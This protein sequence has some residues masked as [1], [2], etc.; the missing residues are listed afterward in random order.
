MH[1]FKDLR[2]WQQSRLFCKSVYLA[3]K[4]FP[5]D[6]RYGITSQMRRAV[7][8]IP[9]NI[10]EGAS[11]KSNKDYSRFLEIALGSCYELET[12]LIIA[13]DLSFLDLKKFEELS[14]K[15]DEIIKMTSKLRTTLNC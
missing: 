10:A 4:N 11:R 9:S 14:S 8:S 1:K 13:N 7:I 12:Q 2:V 15:L 6:E 5:E 3:T